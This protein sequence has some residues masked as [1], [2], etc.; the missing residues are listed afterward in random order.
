[1]TGSATLIQTMYRGYIGRKEGDVHILYIYR[2]QEEVQRIGR[3]EGDVHILYIQRTGGG[4]E[5]RTDRRRCTYTV[6]IQRTGGGTEDRMD[7]NTRYGKDIKIVS[8]CAGIA[9]I[10]GK[11]PI[12]LDG[13]VN[14]MR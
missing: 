14:A 12:L 6:H 2:E 8:K 5:D 10:V 3:I 9:V 4:T 1:M 11:I 13:L 7:K